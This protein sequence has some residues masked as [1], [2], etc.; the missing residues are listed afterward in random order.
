MLMKNGMLSM[1]AS[2]K[3]L[4]VQVPWLFIYVHFSG[5]A[6]GLAFAHP[7]PCSCSICLLLVLR[8]I[9]E[10]DVNTDG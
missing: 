4:T 3:H 10:H 5:E 8:Y 7:H 1:Y 2:V 6:I 9:F